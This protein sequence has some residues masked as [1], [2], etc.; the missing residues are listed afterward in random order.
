M[1]GKDAIIEELRALIARLEA[2]LKQQAAR[3]AELELALAKAKKDSST[4]SKPPSSDIAKPPPK[5]VPGRRKPRR[6]AQPGHQRQLREPL[7]PERVDETIDY[8][9]EQG[10]IQR[11]GL[12]PTGDFEVIQHIELPETPVQ[13][14]EHRLTVYQ[15]ADGQLYVPDCPELKGPI[16]GPRLLAAIGW[17]KSVGHGSYSTVEAWMEDVLQ[18]PVSRGYLAKLCTGAISASL[19]DAYDELTAAI[20]HQ[21][22]LGSDETSLKDNGKKHWIWCITAAT[23]SVFHIAATRSRAVLEKLVGPE[24]TGYLSFDY[25][26][27][28]CSFAWNFWIKA[29]YCWAHL[30]RDMRF[31]ETH[32]DPKT[33]AWAE[34]LLDRSRRLFSAW[35]RREG[36]TEEGFRRSMRT[37]RDRFLEVVRQPPSS[38]EARNL[39][40]RFAIVEY[41][42]EGSSAAGT[43]DL[44]QDYFRFLFADG[45][46]PTNNHSEQQI[47]HC[48]IDRRITQGTRGDAGQRYHE[49][50]WTAIATCRKQQRNF[51]S[52]L[53]DSITAKLQNQP[54]P[55]LLRA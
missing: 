13:V 45:V 40:A 3:I 39:A 10:E 20:P 9:I 29:Q 7:P 36:M 44:S 12:T 42:T 34:Q 6:G 11:L 41:T 49:R 17:M 18:V 32:P 14:T 23:F 55:S 27:A 8:E 33:K 22:Q 50:L 52:F 38:K 46:E 16:F 25:F 43:Y 19:A 51:F 21:A 24:F 1:D 26:S 30:I 15:A 47:R 53:R 2:Q 35:H 5:K 37:H 54:G 48:V 4:S 28:N 31:L